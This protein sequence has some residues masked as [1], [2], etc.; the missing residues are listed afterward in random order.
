MKIFVFFVSI[1]LLTSGCVQNAPQDTSLRSVRQKRQQS[2]VPAPEAPVIAK[3][4]LPSNAEI[5]KDGVLREKGTGKPYCIV[6]KT[7]FEG[8]AKDGPKTTRDGVT[9]CF[10]CP[11]AA[12]QFDKDPAKYAVRKS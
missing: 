11:S 3:N 12:A 7:A 1:S 9:Y 4:T 8:P 5:A 6:M 10:C 2:A